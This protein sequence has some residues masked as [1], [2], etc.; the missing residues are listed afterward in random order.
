LT[1]DEIR[2]A[3]AELVLMYNTDLETC[4]ENEMIQF[5]DLSKLFAPEKTYER[6][7]ELFLYQL[8][9]NR[10]LNDTFPNVEISLRMF[11][12]LMVANCSSELSF[13]KLKFIKNRLRTSMSED[14]F[15]GLTLLSIESDVLRE[16][17]F[18]DIID[19]FA[20]KKA[21]KVCA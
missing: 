15:V 10:R 13:S 21:R 3:A 20:N 2:N 8:L 9:A 17:T 16:L 18:N 7:P 5:G 11:L 6:S 19:E 14:R 12:V 4:T 1:A